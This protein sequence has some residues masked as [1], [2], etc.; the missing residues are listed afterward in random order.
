M[1]EILV[2]ENFA[3]IDGADMNVILDILGELTL[4]A[5][6]TAP[7]RNDRGRNWNLTIHWLRRGPIPESTLTG[8]PT[9]FAKIKDHFV[10]VGKIPPTQLILR[11]PDEGLLRTI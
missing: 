2:E 6:P 8:L 4:E 9:A 11:G 3:R 5:E 1:A 10:A 7:R